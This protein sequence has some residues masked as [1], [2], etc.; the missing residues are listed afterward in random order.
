MQYSLLA[1]NRNGLLYP[2]YSKKL[3][4]AGV[5]VSEIVSVGPAFYRAGDCL[6]PR[7]NDGFLLVRVVQGRAQVELDG[8]LFPLTRDEFV[9]SPPGT[10]EHWV[11]DPT[12]PTVHDYLH[13][14]FAEPPDSRS[15]PRCVTVRSRGL[16]HALFDQ[17]LRLQHQQAESSEALQCRTLELLLETLLSGAEHNEPPTQHPAI[18]RILERLGTAWQKGN[19][20]TPTMQALCLSGGLSKPQLTRVFQR[21]CGDS[22]RRFCEGLRLHLAANCL[23]SSRDSMEEI[24]DFLGYRTQFHFSRSF[25]RH[26]GLAPLQYRKLYRNHP[27]ILGDNPPEL[28]RAYSRVQHISRRGTGR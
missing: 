16:L 5:R 25:K 19:Y 20:Q 21:D 28:L 6:G 2:L 22:P 10:R 8:T 17:V 4:G 11:W 3:Q 7:I 14:T 1:L 12:G 9:L 26:H 13:W 15:W 18:V 23:L 24:A 27:E